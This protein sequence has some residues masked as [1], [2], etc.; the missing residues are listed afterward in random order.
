VLGEVGRG[1]MGAVLRARDPRLKRELALKVLLSQH[2]TRPEVLRRFLEEAQI[3][4]QLQHPGVVPV[5]DLGALPDGRPFFAM[6]LIQ[7]RTLKAL[8]EER[9]SPGHDLPRLLQVF[10]QVAQTLSYAH[11]HGVIHR[12]LKPHN[13]M[14]GEFGEVQVMDWGL[15]KVL[16][17][18]GG[19]L[20]EVGD[21]E[22][23]SAEAVQTA[24]SEEGWET[25]EGAVQG[26]PAYMSPEQARGLKGQIDERADVFALGAILSEILTGQP[27]YGGGARR[28]LERAAAADL[29]EALTRLEGCG[30]DAELIALAWDC[31][32]AEPA[33]RPRDAGVVARRVTI[34]R[35]EVQER[36]RRAELEKAAAQARATEAGKRQRLTLALALAA[37]LLLGL[38][39]GAAWYLRQ[40][41]LQQAEVAARV[42]EDLKAARAELVKGHWREA[43]PALERAEA[44]LPAANDPALAGRLAQARKDRDLLAR[45]DEARLR[46]ASTGEKGG[47][48]FAGSDQQF[49]EAFHAWGLEV[50]QLR[51]EEAA[52]QVRAS[53]L[54]EAVLDAL[55]D[56]TRALREL[57]PQRARQVRAVAERVDDRD[58]RR[59]LR[60]AYG[61]GDQ[62]ALRG[63]L[64]EP[65]PDAL[66]PS[67]VVL[68]ADAL[69]W[70]EEDTRAL[71]VLRGGQR[72]RPGDFWLAF[73]LA[74]A[75]DRSTPGGREE[76][77]RYYTAALALRPDSA[78][79]HT[80][81]GAALYDQGKWA[82]AAAEFRETLRL[83][84]DAELAHF[85]LGNALR[86]Q[87]QLPEAVAEYKTALHLKPDYPEAHCG[88]GVALETQGKQAEALAE[89]REALRLLPDDPVAHFNLGRAL[90]GL[91]KLAEAV[92]EYREALRLQ[93]DFPKARL[94]RA[95]ALYA[96]GKVDEGIAELREA[97]LRR[98]DFPEAHYNLGVALAEQGMLPEAVAEFR[99][100][101]RLQP[102]F[103]KARNNL[104][105]ALNAQGLALA[106]QGKPAEAVAAFRE[107]LRLQPDSPAAHSNLGNALNAQ[108]KA[109]A[110]Q[111]KLAE[112]VAAFREV[113]RLQPDSPAAYCNL[114]LALRGLGQLAESRDHFLHGHE[115]GSKT[116]G[117]R[118]PSAQW[119]K[120]AER[121][122]DL[123]AR[124]PRVLDGKDRPTAAEGLEFAQVCELK[125]RYATA[126]RLSA[127]AFDAQP[128]LAEDLNQQYRYD[129]TRCAALAGCGQGEDNP[130]PGAP[131]GAQLRRQARDWLAADLK[132]LAA[133]A[134]R[135]N[136]QATSAV[137]QPLRHWPQDAALV[138]VRHPWALWRLPSEE[139]AA[140]RQ[141][142]AD[143]AA[144]LHKAEAKD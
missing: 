126:A 97:L 49:V 79:T 144:R 85:N 137:A 88:L 120:D 39:G 34:Y 108:G 20:D 41:H 50:E 14:V 57:D 84:P 48:D 111:G 104:G 98:P 22:T 6:K 105:L 25:R 43:T 129:A 35:A 61:V 27:P 26:T 59:R 23:V 139:R 40:Q 143:V 11:A 72:S 45:L 68:L 118:H 66:S 132:A 64:N 24:R 15:A 74:A 112:A 90:Q 121:L 133:V 109:L 83:K 44:R 119:L 93:P 46:A 30:A 62:A 2:Q 123:E 28:A 140:W 55:D 69:K 103:P 9:P 54:S 52:V 107:V 12:D 130:R 117:W 128:A 13:V 7:G 131:A 110:E 51:P 53:A 86:Q 142:W 78:G 94:N 17:S 125:R 124:L 37:L 75:C 89:F 32:A 92:A 36:L 95:A 67:A 76:A 5:H 31:L 91:N 115:L 101:L 21:Q 29:G 113:L 136:P 63:V 99:E 87:G 10:E 65:V 134:E 47:F 114:G 141:L 56:W 100:V 18:A 82:E 3:G 33:K 60:Q 135:N 16:R 122:A 71:E 38:G 127:D 106:A 4:G 42:E 58:W 102:D 116:P 8:L 80:N 77:V 19:A 70:A 1:G 73:E 138:G 81:L 96:Q